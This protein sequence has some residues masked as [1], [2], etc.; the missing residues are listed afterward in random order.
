MDY[1]QSWQGASTGAQSRLDFVRSVYLWLVGGFAVA[2]LGA[3]SAPLV[4]MALV[5]VAGA[6]RDH[7]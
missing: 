4:A 5:P 7:I 2:A 6:C 1:Q 3:L